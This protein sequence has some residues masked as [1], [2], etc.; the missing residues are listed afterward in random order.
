MSTQLQKLEKGEYGLP[1]ALAEARELKRCVAVRDADIARL[2]KTTNQLQNS[3]D[4]ISDQNL[5]LRFERDLNMYFLKINICGKREKFG[6]TEE[7]IDVSGVKERRASER[8]I[9]E[10]LLKQ[11]ATLEQ[12]KV[13]LKLQVF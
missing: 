3:L 12:E 11:V 9:I 4:E 2:I 8:Q 5:A 13:S 1:E 7:E 10:S 6:V